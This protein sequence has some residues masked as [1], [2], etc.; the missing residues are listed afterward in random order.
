MMQ[1]KRQVILY[2]IDECVSFAC[3]CQEHYES[4]SQKVG[5]KTNAKHNETMYCKRLAEIRACL[6]SCV[7]EGVQRA[8]QYLLK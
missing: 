7:G 2:E 1:R 5:G 8:T 6:L 4:S 3:L